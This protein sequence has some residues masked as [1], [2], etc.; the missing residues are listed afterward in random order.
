MRS[1]SGRENRFVIQSEDIRLVMRV[2]SLAL[3]KLA[4]IVDR[5]L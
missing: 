3:W 2:W 5:L 4:I 1:I